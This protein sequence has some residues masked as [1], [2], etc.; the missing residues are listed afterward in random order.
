MAEEPIDIV[1]MRLDDA[2]K[3]IK[4][5]EGTVVDLTVRKVDGSIEVISLTRDMVELEESYA[6]SANI[7]KDAK[8]SD[9]SIYLNFMLISMIISKEMPQP[10]LPKK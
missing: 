9:L 8:N 7:L 3:L 6:K 2:I 1:G 10:M 5:P 4:G